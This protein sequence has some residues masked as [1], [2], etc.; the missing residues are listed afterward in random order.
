VRHSKWNAILAA[1]PFALA[2]LVYIALWYAGERRIP[3]EVA[4]AALPAFLLEIA[5]YFASASERVRAKLEKLPPVALASLLTAS[6]IPSYVLIARNLESVPSILA[7]SGVASF[8]YVLL[9]KGAAR[10]AGFLV[11]MSLP[12]LFRVF[13]GL[14]PDPHPRLPAN[15][16]GVIMWWRTGL[17]AVLAIRKVQ[18]VGFG[19]MPKRREWW[20]GLREFA[21]FLPIAIVAAMALGLLHVDVTAWDLRFAILMVLTF[22]GTLWFLAVAEEF[23]FRG[24]L[25]Q[26][27][28][29]TLR[30]EIAG[31]LVASAIFGLVHLGYRS[32][33][34]WKFAILAGI[35][36]VFFGRAYLEARSIRAAMVT[37]ACTVTLMKV[38]VF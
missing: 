8:W 12:V 6:S 10:D 1:L 7:L 24:L 31:L 19:L 25:Q 9:R 20:I 3:T 4:A 21:F 26:L 17:L 13:D 27:L 33:P 22:I 16:L 5:L 15:T 11:F 18:G 35:A 14:Y 38:L 30:S 34:N 32:F 37:H 29:R 23:F 2:A 28:A 36:G